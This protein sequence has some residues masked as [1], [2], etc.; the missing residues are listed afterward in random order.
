MMKR[1][2]KERLS[3]IWQR[4]SSNFDLFLPIKKDKVVNFSLWREG[5]AVD[6]E[7]LR[8]AASPKHIVF[9]QTETYLKFK[10]EGKKLNLQTVEAQGDQYVIF[11]VRPCDLHSFKLLDNIFLSEP[12][13]TYYREHR[14]RGT[15]IS[16]GCFDPED[17]CF[18]SSFGIDAGRDSSGADIA[19]WD[20]GDTLL[21][22]IN[23]QRGEELSKA[24]EDL[25]E[26]ATEEDM[27]QLQEMR[28]DLQKI[29]EGLPLSD[30]DPSKIAGTQQE[31][32]DRED[33][34]EEV[35]KRCLA[36]GTCSYVCPTCHCYD[37]QDYKCGEQG[38]R[39]RC[40]DSCMSSDFTLM[41]H[42]NPRTTQMQRVRQRFMHK[43]VYY[44]KNNG[45]DYS[46]VGCGRC[47]E[48]C[49][50]HLDIGKVIKKLG[51]EA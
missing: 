5:E 49:P 37:V 23:T 11:G 7:N 22:E 1:I 2:S 13:D 18:C 14:E 21:W 36:C 46:C 33:I 4:I 20:M 8:T 51:G 31:I 44:P 26:E 29:V 39:F 43:L 28:T 27:E 12:V 32:F 47:V 15:I 24:L 38:E 10:R 30:V 40:W 35:S 9:P 19:L 16:L 45:G 34:W 6:L 48:K 50:A 17:T 41:A 42:G 25:L 3:E